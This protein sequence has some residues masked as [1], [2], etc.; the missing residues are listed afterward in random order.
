[1]PLQGGSL[2]RSH[3]ASREQEGEERPGVPAGGGGLGHG[4]WSWGDQMEQRGPGQQ[5]SGVCTSP[6][7]RGSFLVF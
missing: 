1:M 5:E 2:G 6:L 3:A 4:G 7:R